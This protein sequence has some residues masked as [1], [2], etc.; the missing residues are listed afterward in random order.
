MAFI[1]TSPS[2]TQTLM[3]AVRRA[4]GPRIERKQ[5]NA[6]VDDLETM[7]LSDIRQKISVTVPEQSDDYAEKRSLHQAA[8]L[9]VR[10]E[11]WETLNQ[12]LCGH[13]QDRTT[14]KSGT[15]TASVLAS[16]ARKDIIDTIA[17]GL[18]PSNETG[19]A[20]ASEGVDMLDQVLIDQSSN[21]GVALVVAHAHMDLG[22]A[23]RGQGWADEVPAADWKKFARH[24][25]R[26]TSIL[27]KFDPIE[28]DSPALA[29]ARCRALSGHPDPERHV[30]HFFE[31][32]IDLAPNY[33]KSYRQFGRALLPRWYGSYELLE[34]RAGKLAA[35]T[36]DQWGH[37]AYSLTFMDAMREDKEAIGFVDVALFLQGLSDFLE[38]NPDQGSANKIVAYLSVALAPT[39]PLVAG[40][41]RALHNR[42]A[43]MAAAPEFA[44]KHLREIQPDVWSAAKGRHDYS[45]TPAIAWQQKQIGLEE[46]FGTLS[47]AYEREIL[48]GKHVF[49]HK[50]TVEITAS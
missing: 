46:A 40:S 20:R 47:K 38:A 42:R 36:S 4:M 7:S 26:A 17:S 43:I 5:R 45:A 3:E 48:L 49:L 16:G 10:Q 15:V 25:R 6:R 19:L 32:L 33:A 34:E 29:A 13:D 22:F 28:F 44:R 24:I 50:N 14:T 30:I 23:W 2:A 9:L 35:E 11:H 31:D 27:E 21:Y 41:K 8:H 1:T 18:L 12:L 39:G 37:G